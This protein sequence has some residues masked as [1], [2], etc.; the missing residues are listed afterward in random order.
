MREDA[1]YEVNFNML[2]SKPGMMIKQRNLIREL[3]RTDVGRE[4]LQLIEEYKVNVNLHY[5]Y[6]PLGR[7]V[8]G[9]AL[10]GT[11]KRNNEGVEYGLAYNGRTMTYIWNTQSVRG[12]AKNIIHEVTHAVGYGPC[13]KFLPLTTQKAEVFARVRALSNEKIISFS[14]VKSIIKTVRE[15]Y[16]NQ[17]WC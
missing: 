14:H 13:G 7:E 8:A 4:T 6:P 2:F 1:P 5:G 11:R 15:L 16:P 17:R 10:L 9:V 12:T 3:K